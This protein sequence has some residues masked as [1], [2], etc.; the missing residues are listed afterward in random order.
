MT[1]SDP[2]DLDRHL[3]VSEPVFLILLALADEPLHGYGI[4]LDVERR[5]DGAVTLGTGTLYS[6]IKRL[7]RDGLLDE[8]EAPDGDDEDPRRR[9]Y[10]LTPTGRAVVRAE[11]ARHA[12]LAELARAASVLDR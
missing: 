5:T 11:A 3:P 10:A 1:D 4:L 9:Y 12:R 2:G 7:R 8:T 6:A